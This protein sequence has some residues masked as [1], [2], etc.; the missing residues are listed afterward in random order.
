MSKKRVKCREGHEGVVM[1]YKTMCPQCGAPFVEEEEVPMCETHGI[2]MEK[3][4]EFDASIV[5][6]SQL[7]NIVVVSVRTLEEFECPTCLNFVKKW[8]DKHGLK[9][10]E[11]ERNDNVSDEV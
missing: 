2:P 9:A 4:L 7:A 8:L 11:V 3:G 10:M 6:R 1:G 5:E